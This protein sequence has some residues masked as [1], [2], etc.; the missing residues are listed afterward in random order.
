MST[1]KFPHHVA[2]VSEALMQFSK[3][4]PYVF[5]NFRPRQRAALLDESVSIEYPREGMFDGYHDSDWIY[6]PVRQFLRVLSPGC[7]VLLHFQ[8][9]GDQDIGTAV[10]EMRGAWWSNGYP[11][12]DFEHPKGFD[13]IN[14]CPNFWGSFILAIMN[15]PSD[16][17]IAV[18]KDR[19]AETF[20]RSA[21]AFR[22]ELVRLS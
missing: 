11:R 17:T 2:P 10:I 8:G 7:K 19:D 5:C 21:E 18:R 20:I 22:P 16:A 13:R 6:D 14:G 4:C 9:Y 12:L 1:S 3:A 15:V